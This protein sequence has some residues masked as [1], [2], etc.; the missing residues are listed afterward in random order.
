M[1][2]VV[3]DYSALSGETNKL[4]AL[5]D[6]INSLKPKY[7]ILVAEILLLRLFD[8]LVETIASITNK[9][10]CGAL[11]AD[12]SQPGLIILSR[13]R[14]AAINNMENYGRRRQRRLKWA[15]VKEIKENV[16]YVVAVN[17]HF[18]NVLD[19]HMLFIEEIRWIRNRIAHNNATSRKN[20]RGAVLRYYGAYV[21]S[22][23][24]GILLL[25]PRQNP[26]LMRQ[27]LIKSRILVKTLI[28]G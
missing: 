25:S 23:R 1:V 10:M 26:V 28:K 16:R 13:S 19:S 5:L 20:Y 2:N 21:N 14:V 7:A 12:G 8:S 24:P 22:V 17:E 3:V 15:Q 27:Y 4:I 9:I 11:Y 6:D 18:L